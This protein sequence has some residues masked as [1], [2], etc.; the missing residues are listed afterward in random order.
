MSSEIRPI[1]LALIVDD[2]RLLVAEGTDHVKGE[3]FYRLL[4]GGIDFAESGAEAVARELLEE[5]GANVT[6]VEYVETIENIFVYEGEAGHELC[7]IYTVT[8]GDDGIRERD[9]VHLLDSDHRAV[10]M[11]VD[12]FLDRSERLYPDGAVE[13]LG[14]LV[15]A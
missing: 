1:A 9:E 7:R 11:P 13:L 4:G 5:I 8:L 12:S 10:W 3:R 14:R 15:G 6:Q 2:R